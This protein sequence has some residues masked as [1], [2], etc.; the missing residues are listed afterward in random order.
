MDPLLEPISAEAPCGVDLSNDLVYNDL[1]VAM[2]GTPENQFEVGSAKEPDWNAIRKL[3]EQSLARSKDLQIAV[4]FTVALMQ[5]GGFAGAARGIELLSGFVRTYWETLFPNLD[6]EDKD[7]TQR[8]N[9][10]SQL[11]VEQGSFGDPIKFIERL[12][13]ATI[14]QMPNLVV[15]LAYLTTETAP[16]MGTGATKLPEILASGDPEGTRSGIE[17]LRR[18]V[19]AVHGLDDYLIQ[20]LGRGAAP[21][22]D[23]LIKVLDKG[24]RLFDTFQSAPAALAAATATAAAPVN[25]TP[26]LPAT[27]P[28]AVP[29]EIRSLDDVRDTLAKIRAFYAV[30]EPSSPV[31]LLLRRA[32]RLVGKNFLDLLT[33]LV[34]GSRNEFETLMGPDSGES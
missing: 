21:S 31:P 14:F 17:A 20:T 22:F 19:A 7:P 33:N 25:P 29:G 13:H 4:Y 2:Q 16:G 18:T 24:L 11:A 34:P 6:P 15:T 27:P 9:I 26:F 32:E 1:A 5:T 10:V 30:H 28:V 12:Q 8:V 23:P 3:S